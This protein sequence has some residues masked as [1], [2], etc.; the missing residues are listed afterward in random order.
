MYYFILYIKIY[1][2]TKQYS[3]YTKKDVASFLSL[4]PSIEADKHAFFNSVER[5]AA[6]L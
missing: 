5:I 2:E 3:K 1:S 4:S 6:D